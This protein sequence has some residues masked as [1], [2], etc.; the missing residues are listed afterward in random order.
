MPSEIFVL[1]RVSSRL[2]VRG[3]VDTI[4]GK[5]KLLVY[6]FQR[7]KNFQKVFSVIDIFFSMCADQEIFSFFQTKLAQGIR[8]LYSSPDAS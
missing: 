5:F 8:G 1:P 3:C 2:R 4:T 7:R 6:F